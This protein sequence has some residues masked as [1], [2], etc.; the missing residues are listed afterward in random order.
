MILSKKKTD[1]S[2][3]SHG[4]AAQSLLFRG[5]R[6]L[7]G[8]FFRSSAGSSI[9]PRHILVIRVDDRLGNPILTTPLLSAL[10]QAYPDAELS[11]LVA[12]R[13]AWLF[14]NNDLNVEIIPFNKRWLFQKPWRWAALL[15]ELWRRSFDVVMDAS[16]TH[17]VST[18]SGALCLIAGNA[19][20]I[21]PKRGPYS[22]L[23]THAVDVNDEDRRHERLRKLD[24]L[25]PLAL[26]AS[27]ID[28]ATLWLGSVPQEVQ[29]Q[30]DLAWKT[31]NVEGCHVAACFLGARK[32][33]R[34]PALAFWQGLLMAFGPPA[35]WRIVLLYGNESKGLAQHLKQEL[36]NRAVLGPDCD[37]L[38]LA[39]LMRKASF[40][41][42]PDTGPLH[43][44]QAV[45]RK[46][47]TLLTVDDQGRWAYRGNGNQVAELW[48]N[49]S[50]PDASSAM[51][52]LAQ[53][54]ETQMKQDTRP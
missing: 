30:T 43:L 25:S 44:A 27:R 18:T 6:L 31:L 50:L 1:F 36:G 51:L 14:A 33:D 54:T 4:T 52:K 3:K 20:R 10:R 45:G 49:D 24:L 22:Q 40:V 16:H 29:E 19:L 12:A 47:L 2:R 21:G 32:E 39:A 37:A 42:A 23:Y 26:D 35:S 5:L 28:K 46:T 7:L 34:R 13:H 9:P 15:L 8:R 11:F 38:H 53:L 48:C 17:A 41:V